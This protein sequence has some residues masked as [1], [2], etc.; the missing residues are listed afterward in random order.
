MCKLSKTYF[1]SSSSYK[2]RSDKRYISAAK[3]FK[4]ALQNG[5]LYQSRRAKRNHYD[6][7]SIFTKIISN[8]QLELDLKC[9]GL[10][11]LLAKLYITW[12]AITLHLQSEINA[13]TTTLKRY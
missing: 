2:K 13:I 4:K 6:A 5:H 8:Q 12:S 10:I 3:Y 11:D 7:K 9:M 1:I